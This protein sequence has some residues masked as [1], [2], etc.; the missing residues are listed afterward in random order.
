MLISMSSQPS[1]VASCDARPR[2]APAGAAPAVV[3]PR[4]HVLPEIHRT[5]PR[6]LVFQGTDLFS[7]HLAWSPPV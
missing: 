6:E 1:P 3:E 5:E 4:G 2:V 7:V